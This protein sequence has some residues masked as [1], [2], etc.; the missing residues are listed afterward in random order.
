MGRAAECCVLSVLSAS[1][2][3]RE[4][5]SSSWA[6]PQSSSSLLLLDW[7]LELLLPLR[8]SSLSLILRCAWIGKGVPLS[9]CVDVGLFEF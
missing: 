4:P 7:E 5:K 3:D 9:F 1:E 2:C 8:L 6:D